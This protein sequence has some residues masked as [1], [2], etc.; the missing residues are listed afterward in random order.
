M[1][2][3][4]TPGIAAW[5][6]DF[7]D[8][9]MAALHGKL[10]V[11]VP[12]WRDLA[13]TEVATVAAGRIAEVLS[14][15]ASAVEFRAS[16]LVGTEYLANYVDFKDKAAAAIELPKF[17]ALLDKRWADLRAVRRSLGRAAAGV[18][19]VEL[20]RPVAPHR[21]RGEPVRSLAVAPVAG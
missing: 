15:Q 12:T 11:L 2:G 10:Q 7:V 3:P 6:D 20:R 21:C 19:P 13:R 18:R 8:E 1:L 4:M 5:R 9:F 17:R 16:R 14:Q